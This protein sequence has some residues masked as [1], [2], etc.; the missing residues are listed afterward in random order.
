MILEITSQTDKGCIRIKNEDIGL[1]QSELVTNSP[2]HS[3]INTSGN[4]PVIVAVADGMGGQNGGEFASKTA[5]EKLVEWKNN[6]PENSDFYSLSKSFNEWVTCTDRYIKNFGNENPSL[7]GMGTTLVGIIFTTT[8]V[9]AFNIGDSRLYRLRENWLRQLTKDHSVRNL[10]NDVTT[11][12]NLIYNS[13]G[14]GR[15]PFADYYNLSEQIKDSD[16]FLLC[17]DGLY[18]MMTDDYIEQV[19]REGGSVT[20]LIEAAK[21]AGGYDNITVTLMRINSEVKNG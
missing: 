12:S 21:H 18:D 11:P 7:Q 2:V 14:G 16:T 10:T 3:I 15:E 8:T 9:L 20:Q 4:L 5:V 1:V 19:L 17:S 6:L 13:L